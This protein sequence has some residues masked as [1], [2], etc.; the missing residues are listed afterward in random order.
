M[1]INELEI[2]LNKGEKDERLNVLID[3]KK[4]IDAGEIAKPEVTDNVNNHIHT[5]YSFSPYSPAG[6]VYAAY[7]N[8]LSTAGIMDHDSIAGA[9]EFIKA[10]RIMGVA[11]TVG[12]ELRVDMSKTKLNGRR[13]NNPDQDS[14]AYAIIHGIPPQN[15]DMLQGW[16]APFRKNRNARNKKMCG[17][18]SDM[19]KPHGIKLDFEESV[20]PISQYKNGGTV[21]ERHIC[22]AL[23]KLI[24]AK[25]KTPAEVINFFKNDMNTSVS[26]KIEA[27][28]LENKPEYY[29]YD[30]LGL[31]KAE[32]ITQFYVDACDEC[33]N[34]E[35][36]IKVAKAAGAIS[37]YPY[38]GDVGDSVTGD[39]RTQKFEDDYIDLLFE[40]L[41]K[42]GFNA[43]A[44]MPTR[45][46]RAQLERV[47]KLC[48]KYNL[49]QI[50]GEDINSPRQGFICEAL[51][52]PMFTHLIDATWAL[53]NHEKKSAENE[54]FGMFSQSVIKQFPD[55]KSRVKNFL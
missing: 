22:C 54:D 29:I 51:K 23:A 12:V 1:K 31:L 38:L 15:I 10:G 40:E 32:L 41:V 2:M 52:D 21:T 9:D 25:Y 19:M 24:C 3:L 36:F 44:Y 14:I 8:G 46:T 16:L 5:I 13:I 33:P 42:L 39:K 49:L 11:T 4:K 18:I 28:M 30:I 20:L 6:A 37:A 47:I 50:S 48:D 34:I 35:D 55:I 43:A 7:M 45:N 53:I 27:L 17:N 26:P